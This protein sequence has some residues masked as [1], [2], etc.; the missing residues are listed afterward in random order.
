M[1]AKRIRYIILVPEKK[2]KLQ[3]YVRQTQELGKFIHPMKYAKEKSTWKPKTMIVVCKG[4][5]EYDWIFATNINFRTRV[6]YIW[7]YKRR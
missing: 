2:G 5:D 1:P 6:E 4:I 7:H 3:E